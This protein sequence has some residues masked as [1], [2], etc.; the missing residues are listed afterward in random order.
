[1]DDMSMHYSLGTDMTGTVGKSG[2]L[3]GWSD[4]EERLDGG[5]QG[6]MCVDYGQSC[7]SER[8]QFADV[9]RPAQN[10]RWGKGVSR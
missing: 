6:M 8:K 7:L 5:S 1:M 9:L 4:A 2:V 3:A 10:A